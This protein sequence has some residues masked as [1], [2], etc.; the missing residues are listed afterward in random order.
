MSTLRCLIFIISVTIGLTVPAQ[1]FHTVSGTISDRE[2]HRPLPHVS[3]VA[4]RVGTVTNEQGQFTLK[5]LSLSDTLLFSL[6]GYA[7][8]Q[9][10]CPT[11]GQEMKI[12]LQPTTV[13][14]DEL[15]VWS[16][17][18][19][20]L[21]YE[22][23]HKFP[24]NY[25]LQGTS[26]YGFYREVMRKRRQYI[27]VNE[28]VVELFKSPYDQDVENDAVTV[29]RGRKIS[30][31]KASDTL[32]V[33]LMGGPT[34]PIF[35]DVVKNT[36]LLFYPEDLGCFEYSFNGV[37]KLDDRLHYIVKMTPV[38]PKPYALFYATLYID[39]QSLAISRA[40]LH[41]DMRNRVRASNA[42]LVHRPK[43]L[44]F[45]PVE[46]TF[47]IYYRTENGVT[48]LNYVRNEMRFKCDWH[49]RL[50][51]STYSV[52]SEFVVTNILPESQQI[53]SRDS[54]HRR[55]SLYDNVELFSEP[56]FWGADNII[57]PTE[58]L[59]RAIERLRRSVQQTLNK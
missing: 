57:E 46:L 48:H 44:R 34:L 52:V 14:L 20:E 33:K 41:L 54:Y 1:D 31:F 29:H 30:S 55:E 56:D 22:A 47:N 58:S 19:G 17:N 39:Q 32:M 45:T 59:N 21:V 8:Q 49:R 9:L 11:D 36:E 23:I 38:A 42:M 15:F 16:L 7:S 50:F 13:N 4:G 5:V 28:A 40:D 43:G 35:A 12:Q 27:C 10:P 3:V 37:E 2:T 25:S 18:A 24:D 26:Y 6:I 51:A 53:R